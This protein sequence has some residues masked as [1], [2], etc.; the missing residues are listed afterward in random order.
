MKLLGTVAITLF[1]SAISFGQ[2]L[3]D[4]IHKTDNE[5]YTDALNEF[6][7][8]VVKEPANGENYF[9]FGDYYLVKGE[10]D[11]AKMMWAKGY[12]VDQISPMSVVG[13][14]RVLWLKGDQAAAKAEFLKA[15]TLTKKNKIKNAEVNRGI[16]KIYIEAPNKNLDEAILLLEDAILKDPKNEDSYLLLGDALLEK[17]PDNG[18]PA[19]KNYNK[20]LDINPKSPRGIVRVAK[21]YQRARNYEL[22]NEKYKDAKKIDSTYAPAYRENAE[23]NMQFK[24]ANKAIENWRRYL[25]LNNTIEARYRYATSMFIGKQHC[26]A[27]T[28][29]NNLRQKGFSNLYTERMLAYSYLECT[30]ETD[31]FKKGI[32]ASDRFF[33][34]APKEKVTYLDYKN[35]GALLSK[36]GSDSLAIV[37]YENSSRLNETAAKELAGELAKLY[38]KAK[39][40]DK[41][42]ESYNLK[43]TANKLSPAEEYDLGKCYYFGPKNYPLADSAFARVAKLSPTYAPAYWWRA[44]TNLKME[45]TDPKAYLWLSKPFYDKVIEIVKPEDRATN[46]N[47]TMVMESAKYLGDYYVRSEAK[48]LEKA[49]TYWEIVIAIDPADAQAKAFLGLK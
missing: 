41:A 29:L 34:I 24:Q 49:K 46:T 27:I 17:T 15:Q 6:N 45:S 42:I 4:A 5:R 8:L 26:E 43:V 28:E 33:A 37:E 40:Y 11:S 32:E 21:L 7:A 9:Y 23:L 35:R 13:N 10:L 2:T 20:V 14:G 47:K 1:A 48:D 18:S 31:A 39:K 19:I 22:A 3:Q 16:A 38:S 25:E 44:R 12:S 36:S 30:T